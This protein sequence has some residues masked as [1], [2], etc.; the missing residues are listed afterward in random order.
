MQHLLTY[1]PN[2]DVWLVVKATIK[3]I[4]QSVK[5][6]LVVF[7]NQRTQLSNQ[8][9]ACVTGSAVSA[10]QSKAETLLFNQ[11]LDTNCLFL[12]FM[13]LTVNVPP[14]YEYPLSAWIS[15]ECFFTVPVA[16]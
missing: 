4:D 10:E 9:L 15:G 7:S 1:R 5:P 2:E 16:S 6:F 3:R 11:T 13:E 12:L 8:E 14:F